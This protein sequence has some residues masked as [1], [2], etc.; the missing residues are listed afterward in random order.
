MTRP[1]T[2]LAAAGALIVTALAAG[3]AAAAPSSWCRQDAAQGTTQQWTC[4]WGPV[5]VAGY[6]V[7]QSLTNAPPHP[8]V[9]G[10]ITHLDVDVT[11]AAGTS[12]PISRLML[13]H[14]VF[15]NLGQSL[16]GARDRTCGQF[17]M[18]DSQTTVPALA[19]RFYAA[20]EERA[21]MDLP[22]GYGYPLHREDTWGM[23]WMFMNHRAR[24]DRAYIRYHVTVDVS[25]AW[26][27]VVPYWLDVANC[28]VDPVYDV[29]GGGVAGSVHRRSST[30][31]MPEAGRV[32]AAGGHV[33]GGARDLTVSEPSCAGR[34][35]W[36]NTPAWGLASHPFYRVRPV[37]HEPGPISMSGIRSASGIPVAKGT[38][39]RLTSTYDN[40]TPHTRVMGIDILYLAPDPA[41]TEACPAIPPDVETVATSAP[42]RTVAP[43]YS[44]PLTGLDARGRAVTITRPPGRTRTLRGDA[45]LRVTDNRFTSPNVVVPAGSTITWRF[46]SRLL[47]NVTVAGG[48]RGFSSVNLDGGRTYRRT[49][50]VPGTYRLFCALHPVAM[51]E[52]VVVRK[53]RSR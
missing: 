13:H 14:I 32:V 43:R 37:L 38:P 28:D 52:T 48:P 5:D 12:V 26:A 15:L 17:R 10:G 16:G 46:A 25:Q 9:D 18:W 20:G 2:I 1:R 49:L 24:P 36:T 41:V 31:T 8:P 3:P 44:V 45:T 11:D 19:E 40:R 7:K 30:F 42:H 6:E 35:L 4:Q 50:N 29:P 34:A 39:L 21:T 33:H 22:A 23:T 51:T 27:P 53:R 47:H